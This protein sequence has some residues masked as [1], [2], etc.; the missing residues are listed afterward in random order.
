MLEKKENPQYWEKVFAS[1]IADKGLVSRLCKEHLK[2][3]N[4]QTKTQLKDRH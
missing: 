3:N 4:K 2:L 1:H